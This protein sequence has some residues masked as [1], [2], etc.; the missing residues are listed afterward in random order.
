MGFWSGLLVFLLGAFTAAAVITLCCWLA[1][2]TRRQEAEE[3]AYFGDPGLTSQTP[4]P[5]QDSSHGLI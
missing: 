2:E 3:A 5:P 1:T 4:K